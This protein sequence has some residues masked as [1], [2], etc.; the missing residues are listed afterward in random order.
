[1]SRYIKSNRNQG[2]LPNQILMYFHRH[3]MNKI[4]EALGNNCSY[5]GHSRITKK[6]LV[7]KINKSGKEDPKML[8]LKEIESNHTLVAKFGSNKRDIT[9]VLN[10][11]PN[12]IKAEYYEQLKNDLYNEAR[13]RE[14][15]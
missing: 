15:L 7:P 1:M 5:V 2:E 12:D 13:K 8:Q 10:G 6:E 11:T 9:A 14:L 4:K 3:N